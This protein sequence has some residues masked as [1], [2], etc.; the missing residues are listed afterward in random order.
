MQKLIRVKGLNEL[1]LGGTDQAPAPST[2]LLGPRA[3]IFSQIPAYF[4]AGLEL[5]STVRTSLRGE[6]SWEDH[7]GDPVN[8]WL[9]QLKAQLVLMRKSCLKCVV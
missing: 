2:A 1:L 7:S 6:Q 9:E 8:S 5:G 4:G 3:A